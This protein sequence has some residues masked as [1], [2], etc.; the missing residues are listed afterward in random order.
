M[1]VPTATTTAAPATS[2]AV[3]SKL[4][5]FAFTFTI[6]GCVMYVLCMFFNL[7]LVTYHPAVNKLDLGWVA[8][9]S[10][11]GPAMYWYGWTLTTVVVATVAG[12]VATLLPETVTKK[13]PL[14]L[15]WLLPMLTVPYMIYDLRQWWFH[16]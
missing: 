5:T 11:E 8:A 2:A 15:I 7:P 1:S 3:S 6:A 16:P 4:R 12:F 10:G 9:R 14:F 13:I